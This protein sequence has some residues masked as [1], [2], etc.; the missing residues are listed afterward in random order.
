MFQATDIFKNMP[1]G[2]SQAG[3][4]P[5]LLDFAMEE[6]SEAPR[7]MIKRNSLLVPDEAYDE[8]DE[9]DDLLD[10]FMQNNG[11]YVPDNVPTSQGNVLRRRAEDVDKAAK[12]YSSLIMQSMSAV[13]EVK[14]AL[15]D[16]DHAGEAYGS[17][18]LLD[19]V[20]NMLSELS[21]TS[22]AEAAQLQKT[23]EQ[24]LSLRK[25]MAGQLKSQHELLKGLIRRRIEY[26]QAQN[27]ESRAQCDARWS[28]IR[29]KESQVKELQKRVEQG[30]KP[31]GGISLQETPGAQRDGLTL[32][33]AHS[34]LRAFAAVLQPH[35]AKIINPSVANRMP[36]E[37]VALEF[38]AAC[39][40]ATTQVNSKSSQLLDVSLAEEPGGLIGQMD[41]DDSPRDPQQM[42]NSQIF[43]LSQIGQSF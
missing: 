3:R 36:S 7:N 5:S 2:S 17:E 18:V 13:S 12:R 35:T 14:T 22:L 8:A 21:Q 38:L 25:K 4:R 31:S 39:N 41:D 29:E 9:D 20:R 40:E 6:A 32:D 37:A 43:M 34:L 30:N 42:S 1:N 23:A 26:A 27:E 10:G 15:Y 19:E 24:H 16:A 28:R 33:G 11:E